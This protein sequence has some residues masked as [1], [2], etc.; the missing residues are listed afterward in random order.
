MDKSFSPLKYALGQLVL[1][2]HKNIYLFF[3]LIISDPIVVSLLGK[4]IES[5]KTHL[6]AVIE[7]RGLIVKPPQLQQKYMKEFFHLRKKF[8]FKI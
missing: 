2:F 5:I 8:F 7:H 1:C 4:Y 6:K 3:I